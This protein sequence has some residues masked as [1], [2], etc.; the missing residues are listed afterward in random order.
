MV[1]GHGVGGDE[2]GVEGCVAVSGRV[3]GG[4]GSRR[5]GLRRWWFLGGGGR[6]RGVGRWCCGGLGGRIGGPTRG[7]ARLERDD[8]DEVRLLLEPK[9][10]LIV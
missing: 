1:E 4:G 6:V 2:E 8:V 9:A 3:D 10:L 5:G 7:F